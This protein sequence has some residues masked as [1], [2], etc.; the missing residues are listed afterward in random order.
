[1]YL[2]RDA[3]I[4]INA[5]LHLPST[6]RE[7]DWDIEL[8]DPDR[9]DEFVS[10]LEQNTLTVEQKIALMSLILGSF[11]DLVIQ[12]RAPRELWERIRRLLQEDRNLYFALMKRWVPDTIGSDGYAIS[13]LVRAAGSEN[14]IDP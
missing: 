11:E 5:I 14:G 9:A 4:F 6:G 1:M 7:Q 10:F 8:A 12:K 13:H 3:I 2:T